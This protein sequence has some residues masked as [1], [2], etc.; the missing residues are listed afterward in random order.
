MCEGASVGARVSASSPY[1]RIT[2]LTPV[3]AGRALAPAAIG[4]YL[5][6]APEPR[7][8]AANVDRQQRTSSMSLPLSVDGTDRRTDG[9]TPDSYTE[10]LC[11]DKHAVRPAPISFSPQ[12]RLQLTYTDF[13]KFFS[14]SELSDILCASSSVLRPSLLYHQSINQS[15]NPSIFISGSEPIEQ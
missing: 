7:R 4:R 13:L 2:T 15:I 11:I 1:T 6:L 14:C 9:Q 8:Q 10:S 5:L 12:Q 3:A